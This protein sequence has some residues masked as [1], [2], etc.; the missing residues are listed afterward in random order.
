MTRTACAAALLLLSAAAASAQSSQSSS[1]VWPE[2]QIHY[3]LD[4]YDKLIGTGTY[5]RNRDSGTVYQGEVGGLFDHRFADFLSGR[6]GY[7]HGFATDGSSYSEDRLLTEQT[8]R[9]KLPARVTVD[10][11]TR[12]DFRWLNSGYSMR[13]RE[14]IQA[15]RDTA[16]GDYVFGP[17]VSAE[18]Y[19]DT[20]YDQFARYRLIAGASFPIDARWS[21]EP[22]LAHQVDFAPAS[23]IVD[24][25]GIVLTVS[26]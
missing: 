3:R 10:F 18:I 16:I 21:L 8:V 22:Y 4:E 1:E 11:R 13:F 25:L 5:S 9:V 24:A 23:A 26:F 17:Y 7:R 20:R 19:Y 14:R 6:I 12:E 15:Q 2:F